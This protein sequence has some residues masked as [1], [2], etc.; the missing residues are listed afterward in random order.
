VVRLF[1][2]D[3]KMVVYTKGRIPTSN[4]E[5][6]CS[7]DAP[8]SDVPMVVLINHGSASGSEIVAGALQDHKRAFVMGSQSFGKASV[9][10]VVP[11]SGGCGIRLTTAKY[12]T[13]LGR[14]IHRDEKTKKG[15]IDPDSVIDIKPEV[16]AKL[17]QQE[18][19]T[20]PPGE[21]PAEE[22]KKERV[23]D[24]VLER[25]TELLKARETFIRIK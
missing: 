19:I 13:P 6:Y 25:A 1:I 21:E 22:E 12:Y 17:Q 20:Y 24:V 3:N 15:G 7:K 18:M 5:Y 11:L 14:G 4:R 2:G 8:Y 9:Q 16:E 10:T 23:E